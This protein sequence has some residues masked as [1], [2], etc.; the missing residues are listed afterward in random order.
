VPNPVT[1][2][3]FHKPSALVI[4]GLPGPLSFHLKAHAMVALQIG[5]KPDQEKRQS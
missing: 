3:Q 5:D 2:I 4:F 1:D